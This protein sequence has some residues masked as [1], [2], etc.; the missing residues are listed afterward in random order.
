MN[1]TILKT[2]FVGIFIWLTVSNTASAN[3]MP[4]LTKPKMECERLN[5][6]GLRAYKDGNYS[7]ALKK[8]TKAELIA[9]KNNLLQHELI[10][11]I[12]IAKAF[13]RMSNFGEALKY[14][15]DALEIANKS[16]EVKE[17]RVNVLSSIGS[18]Y[19]KERDY[20]SALKYCITAYTEA[21]KIKSLDD[22]F[23]SGIYISDIYNKLHNY[24]QSQKYLDE[25]KDIS[26]SN[27]DKLVWQ[28]NYAESIFV[29]GNI[30]EAQ[31]IMEDIF[32]SI[33]SKN[34]CYIRVVELLSKI[35][36]SQNKMN[37][38]VLFAKKGLNRTNNLKQHIN[39]YDRLSDLYLRDKQDKISLQYKDSI[40]LL[41]DSLSK[42]VKSSFF[43]VS[44]VKFDEKDYQNAVIL[45]DK[46]HAFER[47]IYIAGL[48]F[49]VI[50]IFIIYSQF[51]NRL[52]KGRR[53]NIILENKIKIRRLEM[54]KLKNNISEKNKKISA[55]VLYTSGRN[56]LIDKILESLKN[57]SSSNEL[58]NNY[59]NVLKSYVK[60][61]EEGNE[62]FEHF[63]KVNPGFLN[64]LKLKHPDLSSNDIRF[65]SYIYMGLSMDEISSIL[66]ITSNACR[67]R[68]NR[69]LEK[70]GQNK[71]S[72]LF[73]YIM[74]IV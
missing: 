40:I 23:N 52:F 57:T 2:L 61:E 65:I 33:D 15:L 24:K 29:E 41:K 5:S 44:S 43:D 68:K 45:T 64:A 73:D 16:S 50:F 32:K 69:I 34:S 66:S 54:E 56:E 13:D 3:E 63:E 46:K 42:I 55:K 22:R 60:K 17:E 74:K 14:F 26:V 20:K 53:E 25:I 11:K 70:M 39:L 6:L 51:K 38:A 7:E 27:E 8:F 67:V 72:S 10:S 30:E 48:I 36:E 31:K 59:T 12:N 9:E 18:I 35:Y 19:L 71:E 47:K 58:V 28:A 21:E 4:V 49:G 1:S 37:L 62:L